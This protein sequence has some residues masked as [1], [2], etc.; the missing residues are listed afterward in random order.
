MLITS[1]LV[2]LGYISPYADVSEVDFMSTIKYE[3]KSKLLFERI[4]H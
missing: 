4:N 2:R 1:E 3:W